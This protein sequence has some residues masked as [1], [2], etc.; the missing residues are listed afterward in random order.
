MIRF[1]F[2]FFTHAGN[3]HGQSDLEKWFIFCVLLLLK[4]LLP[5]V[6][7]REEGHNMSFKWWDMG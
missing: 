4:S 1:V 6:V 5:M 3:K 7:F 2:V